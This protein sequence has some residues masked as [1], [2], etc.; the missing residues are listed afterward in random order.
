MFCIHACDILTSQNTH[1]SLEHV[2]SARLINHRHRCL[3]QLGYRGLYDSS[4]P[5]CFPSSSGIRNPPPPPHPSCCLP[6][7]HTHTHTQQRWT[8]NLTHALVDLRFDLGPLSLPL[9]F[10]VQTTVWR[11]LCFS[12]LITLQLVFMCWIVVSQNQDSSVFS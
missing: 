11:D 2:G 4:S 12:L 5:L 7:A 3:S 1:F 8:H 6:T 9:T 10:P